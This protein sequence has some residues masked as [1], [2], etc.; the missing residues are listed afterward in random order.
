M[1]YSGAMFPAWRGD[2]FVGALSGEAL[3]RVHLDGDTATKADQWPMDA[4]IREVEQAPDGAIWLLQ[5]GPSSGR[6]LR[7]TPR[8][9]A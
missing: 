9:P 7:L 1:I 4:R 6:L 3:I 5:D 2:A 8:Q